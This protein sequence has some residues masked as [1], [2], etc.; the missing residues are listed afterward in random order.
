MW[1]NWLG[2]ILV[3]FGI[4]YCY[5]FLFNMLGQSSVFILDIS[6]ALNEEYCVDYSLDCCFLFW[7]IGWLGFNSSYCVLIISIKSGCLLCIFGFISRKFKKK[8]RESGDRVPW[9]GFGALIENIWRK[10]RG[11]ITSCQIWGVDSERLDIFLGK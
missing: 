4:L 9:C 10:K 8:K 2:R 1:G 6:H 3:L 7:I 11:N 5:I